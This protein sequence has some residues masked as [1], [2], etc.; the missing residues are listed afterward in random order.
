MVV[1]RHQCLETFPCQ[2]PFFPIRLGFSPQDECL[3]FLIHCSFS[4]NSGFFMLTIFGRFCLTAFFSTFGGRYICIG[5]PN[6]SVQLLFPPKFL[7]PNE[8]NQLTIWSHFAVLGITHDVHVLP[9]VS[10]T[11]DACRL[12]GAL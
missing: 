2:N 7:S 5:C 1:C 3:D 12:V 8:I 6:T 4:K 11:S 10:P 9:F